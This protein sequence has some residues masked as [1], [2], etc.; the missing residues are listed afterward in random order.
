MAAFQKK[1]SFIAFLCAHVRSRFIFSMLS[2][3]FKNTKHFLPK[4]LYNYLIIMEM[5][6]LELELPV[7]N[8]VLP[9][10]SPLTFA[11]AALHGCF[12]KKCSFIAFFCAHVRSQF[13]FSMLS[14]CFKNTKHFLPKVLYNYLI[15]LEMIGLEPTTS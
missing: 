2:T 1:C 14:T 9:P 11:A 8:I 3:C 7:G 15:L 5:I 12:S 6:G 4:V 10:S 13:I